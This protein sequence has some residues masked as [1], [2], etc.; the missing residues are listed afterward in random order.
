MFAGARDDVP[1]L[2]AG[3]DVFC[4]PSSAEGLPIVV[5]EAMAAARPIVAS[6]AGGTP[7]LVAEGV[8][9]LL[10]AAEDP[11]ALAAALASL[12]ADPARARA[13]GEAGRDRVRSEFSLER[14]TARVLDLYTL[15]STMGA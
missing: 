8:T 2:L 12:L 6:A 3:C 5:L 1:A 7:E 10:V 4:L 15:P 11:E 13:M 9:G 14:S